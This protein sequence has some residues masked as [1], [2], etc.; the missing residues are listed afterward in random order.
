MSRARIEELLRSRI[1]LDPASAGPGLVARAIQRRMRAAG[2]A[3]GET[4]RYARRI[5]ASED[6]FQE[7]VEEVVIPESWFFRDEVP[8]RLIAERA[9]GLLAAEPERPAFRV[10]CMPCA[11]GEE[12][13][14]AAMALLDAGL[15]GPRIHID[16]V[17]LSQSALARA[18]R[19]IY[20]ENSFRTDDLGFRSRHFVRQKEGFAL[21]PEVV[22]I[23][24]FHHLNLLSSEILAGASPYD[25]I[26]CRNLLIYLDPAARG[27]VLAGV[28]RLLE[29]AGLL[30]LGHAEQ[31]GLLGAGFRPA[32]PRGSFAFERSAAAPA[33]LP[34]VFP[35]IVPSLP[36]SIQRPALAQLPAPRRLAASRPPPSNAEAGP[37]QGGP[38]PPGSDGDAPRPERLDEAARLAG[39]G[40]HDE[41]T[42]L[43]EQDL[44]V[45]G[46]SPAAYVL[47]GMI[48]QAAGDRVRAQSC[49]EKAVYLDARHEEALLALALL[50]QRR[51]DLAAATN[52]RR[53]AERAFQENQQT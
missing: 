25:V 35:T 43:C 6:E 52:Y 4:E 28:D 8:F 15:D 48:R 51:G 37:S 1:G 46:P 36:T 17:D 32:G 24:R 19:A 45:R 21:D 31:L 29:P 11:A 41:A 3:D 10:L 44:N 9:V 50:A 14:S 39:L 13:Y 20:S 47:L 38:A 18:E 42:R 27:R 33:R 30:I 40:R 2:L 26:F 12:P 22:R 7:L 49:F 34:W 53:R 16:A 5:E 23:V